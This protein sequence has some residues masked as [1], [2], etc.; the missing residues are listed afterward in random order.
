MILTTHFHDMVVQTAC[1]CGVRDQ[2]RETVAAIDVC[3]HCQRTDAMRRVEVAIAV[4]GMR[5]SPLGFRERLLAE[6][7]SARAGAVAEF[8]IAE[9]VLVATLQMNELAK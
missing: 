8:N 4:D 7:R 6:F 9:V 1:F 3:H 5:R 2:L